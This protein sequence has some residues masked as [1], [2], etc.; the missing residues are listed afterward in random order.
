M[1]DAED[2]NTP[3]EDFSQSNN[4]DSEGLQAEA[5]QRGQSPEI[6]DEIEQG[7]PANA[8]PATKKSSE[9][10]DSKPAVTYDLDTLVGRLEKKLGEVNEVLWEKE[11]MQMQFVFQSG[12]IREEYYRRWKAEA[13]FFVGL[14]ARLQKRIDRERKRL[15][16]AG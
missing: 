11:G 14:A 3:N 6:N 12:A 5:E 2:Q 8:P 16:Q 7:E 15:S 1:S 10:G 9:R 13:N 4:V